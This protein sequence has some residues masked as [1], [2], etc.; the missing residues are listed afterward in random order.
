MALQRAKLFRG[1]VA[2]NIR[3]GK[4]DADEEEVREAAQAAQALDFIQNMPKGFDSIVERGGV[5]LSGGQKQRIS[6]ARALVRKPRLLIL[7]DSSSALDYATD[8]RLRAAL[9]EYQKKYAMA[10]I[11]VSQRVSSLGHAQEILLL[12]DGRVLAQGDHAA[13]YGMSEAYRELCAIQG[14]DGGKG[15]GL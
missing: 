4:A 8:A 14:I 5:N 1:S 9:S 6:I 10:C 12:E 13:L 2:E 15:G 3:W 11:V 7:D